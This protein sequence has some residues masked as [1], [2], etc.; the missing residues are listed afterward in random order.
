MSAVPAEP[1]PE[2]A[3]ILREARLSRKGAPLPLPRSVS[4]PPLLEALRAYSRAVM[5]GGLWAGAREGALVELVTMIQIRGRGE[6]S[7]AEV[8]GR[9]RAA[10]EAA[11]FRALVAAY[12]NKAANASCLVLSKPEC[13]GVWVAFSAFSLA[14]AVALKQSLPCCPDGSLLIWATGAKIDSMPTPS[15]PPA[16]SLVEWYAGIPQSDSF[17]TTVLAALAD[18]ASAQAGKEMLKL[19]GAKRAGAKS[20]GALVSAI[21]AAAAKELEKKRAGGGDERQKLLPAL[22]TIASGSVDR[23]PFAD[24]V[25][26]AVAVSERVKQLLGARLDE[27]LGRDEAAVRKLQEAQQAADDAT[28]HAALAASKATA[29]AHVALRLAVLHDAAEMSLELA[30]KT[31]DL[32]PSAER[33]ENEKQND[34]AILEETKTACYRRDEMTKRAREALRNAAQAEEN[35]WS[36][37]E[38]TLAVSSGAADQ[39]HLVRLLRVAKSAFREKANDHTWAAEVPVFRDHV[40]FKDQQDAALKYL[41]KQAQSVILAANTTAQLSVDEDGGLSSAYKTALKNAVDD[42]KTK[43]QEK[44][45][46]LPPK[47]KSVKTEAKALQTAETDDVAMAA[48][49]LAHQAWASGIVQTYLDGRVAPLNLPKPLAK[50]KT[51]ANKQSDAVQLVGDARTA[52]KALFEKRGLI[53]LLDEKRQLAR[54]ELSALVIAHC[55]ETE[56]KLAKHAAAADACLSGAWGASDGGSFSSTFAALAIQRVEASLEAARL[57]GD[58]AAA[59]AL[60]AEAFQALDVAMDR[61]LQQWETPLLTNPFGE[62]WVAPLALL[63]ASAATG[64]LLGF[65]ARTVGYTNTT[66]DTKA[67]A[68]AVVAAAPCE[69]QVFKATLL[70]LALHLDGAARAAELALENDP[71]TIAQLPALVSA[72]QILLRGHDALGEMPGVPLSVRAPFVAAALHTLLRTLNAAHR[73][74]SDTVQIREL[75]SY[76]LYAAF[77]GRGTREAGAAPAPALKADE[78]RDALGSLITRLLNSDGTAASNASALMDTLLFFASLEDPTRDTPSAA[79][80]REAATEAAEIAPRAA[81]PLALELLKGCAKAPL[82]PGAVEAV[83]AKIHVAVLGRG[84]S[85]KLIKA[86]LPILPLLAC[87]AAA[88]RGKAGSADAAIVAA[89]D[90]LA[91]ALMSRVPKR[92]PNIEWG[93]LPRLAMGDA[94]RELEAEGHSGIRLSGSDLGAVLSVAARRLQGA[95]SDALPSS[96]RPTPTES[97]QKK[98][99]LWATVLDTV[100]LAGALAGEPL[101][102]VHALLEDELCITAAAG[103]AA[104]GSAP[105]VKSLSGLAKSLTDRGAIAPAAALLTLA[106]LDAAAV[107]AAAHA[108]DLTSPLLRGTASNDAPA[109]AP[110]AAKPLRLALHV[111]AS[112]AVLAKRWAESLAASGNSLLSVDVQ[113]VACIDAFDGAVLG[114]APFK[115]V[116]KVEMRCVKAQHKT[117]APAAL[118]ELLAARADALPHSGRDAVL[119]ALSDPRVPALIPYPW[120]MPTTPESNTVALAEAYERFVRACVCFGYAPAPPPGATTTALIPPAN[121]PLAVTLTPPFGGDPP[122]PLPALLVRSAMLIAG[123]ASGGETTLAFLTAANKCGANLHSSAEGARWLRV[124]AEFAGGAGLSLLGPFADSWMA[125]QKVVAYQGN[126]GAAANRFAGA[127]ARFSSSSPPLDELNA[128][129]DELVGN[130]SA[131]KSAMGR[132]PRGAIIQGVEVTSH[133][134]ASLPIIAVALNGVLEGTRTSVGMRSTAQTTALLPP[135]KRAAPPPALSQSSRAAA[136]PPPWLVLPPPGSELVTS[137]DTARRFAG[138]EIIFRASDPGLRALMALPIRS[139]DAVLLELAK[140]ADSSYAPGHI[141]PTDYPLL[142]ESGIDACLVAA[143]GVPAFIVERGIAPATKQSSVPEKDTVTHSDG[144]TRYFCDLQ[145]AVTL[146]TVLPP[147]TTAD[148]LHVTAAAIMRGV[149][150]SHLAGAAATVKFTDKS[151]CV[152]LTL[153]ALP[154]DADSEREREEAG[155]RV[156]RFY[157]LTPSTVG[158]LLATE[159]W[160]SALMGGAPPPFLFQ[161]SPIE[162]APETS[163]CPARLIVGR[164]GVGKTLRMLTLLMDFLMRKAE[165]GAVGSGG[166]RVREVALSVTLSAGLS[167]NT[168]ATLA[169][170]LATSGTI[171]RDDGKLVQVDAEVLA[172]DSLQSFAPAATGKRAPQRAVAF[173]T[174]RGLLQNLTQAFNVSGCTNLQGYSTNDLSDMRAIELVARNKRIGRASL[175]LMRTYVLGSAAAAVKGEQLTKEDL[176]ALKGSGVGANTLKSVNVEDLFR[177]IAILQDAMKGH[178]PVL[179]DEASRVLRLHKA[180]SLVGTMNCCAFCKA[181]ARAAGPRAATGAAFL[182]QFGALPC[183]VRAHLDEVQDWTIASLL[184]IMRVTVD[185]NQLRFAGDSA[186]AIFGGVD[187]TF[188]YFTTQLNGIPRDPKVA[189]LLHGVPTTDIGDPMYLDF[190]YRAPD[191]LFRPAQKIVTALKQLFPKGDLGSHDRGVFPGSLPSLFVHNDFAELLRL[192]QARAPDAPFTWP[193]RE[194]KAAAVI[195]RDERTRELLRKNTCLGAGAPV[196]T[197]EESKGLEFDAVLLC[198]LLGSNKATLPWGLLL[199][200]DIGVDDAAK[201]AA[202]VEHAAAK[203][204]LDRAKLDAPDSATLKRLTAAVRVAREKEQM[205]SRTGAVLGGSTYA[206]GVDATLPTPD[207]L[208][209]LEHEMK[210]LNVA[211]TRA[212]KTL[213]IFEGKVDLGDTWSQGLHR[214]VWAFFM[215]C[216]AVVPVLPNAII[217]PLFPVGR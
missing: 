110:L 11:S 108:A 201:R 152:A 46:T 179:I 61:P 51:D 188:K 4:V 200:D 168:C 213:W 185:P 26:L 145:N 102:E 193:L 97:K 191:P 166:R 136:A 143:P 48:G 95:L 192:L 63:E 93:G 198:N 215:Q 106:E 187:F 85:V 157:P 94:R 70:V 9:Q 205:H 83:V 144:S 109:S 42:M 117:C 76:E 214:A 13:G 59:V 206:V 208:R 53:T 186:Q 184:L 80:R 105:S 183:I 62:S 194:A 20:A 25:S 23:L 122:L 161:L 131:L 163:E 175:A 38:S 125:E 44:S 55:G 170:A 98:V 173:L 129:V 84:E 147:S 40:F 135:P 64:G 120:P 112:A 172:S 67:A 21:A 1:L 104:N 133:L 126:A 57:L 99:A 190:C 165:A 81:V 146:W 217:E 199:G 27:A 210:L 202:T 121:A 130:I 50:R 113:S 182:R 138:A 47:L 36:T 153:G 88:S 139:R 79:L 178:T 87:I 127:L 29:A 34:A 73:L 33:K 77:V 14:R 107:F 39:L 32:K 111:T 132:E 49:Y 134:D 19:E 28:L 140:C 65:V 6:L 151:G 141:F 15:L 91:N 169:R 150:S 159:V 100:L 43:D 119:A 207:D 176:I 118:L 128:F 54:D 154:R 12:E 162:A 72:A 89:E 158:G 66:T 115:L 171:L 204:A 58:A 41:A 3:C 52:A 16:A 45:R 195:V 68:A 123:G 148:E 211:L 212:C 124:L 101:S 92:A 24:A 37:L 164:A 189:G 149:W 2:L 18:A 17:A 74:P 116:E 90:F 156:E 197:I 86:S 78:T 137:V 22:R 196:Y 203:L 180:L 209:G 7:K 56:T 30:K 96:S 114:S 69:R 155:R 181:H 75:E 174:L 160:A 71:A 8:A 216:G 60:R 167:Q 35:A 82:H 142:I 177:D 103:L 10:A 5:Q 31:P